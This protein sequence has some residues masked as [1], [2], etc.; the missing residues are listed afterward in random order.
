L[1]LDLLLKGFRDVILILPCAA[2]GYYLVAAVCAL[3][4]FRG[5]PKEAVGFTPAVSI[6][7]PV[8][9]VD[10]EAYENFASFCR[11]DYPDYEVL[12]GVSDPNDPAIAIIERVIQDFP[13][14]RI[15]LHTGM[16]KLGPNDKASILAHLAREASHDLLVISD[17]DTRATP[18]CLRAIA[19]P[20]RDSKVGAVTCLYR[21]VKAKSFGDVMEA[22]GISSDFFGGVFVAQQFA[23]AHFAL[24]AT[25]AITRNRLE[26]IGGFESLAEFLLDDFE[27]GRRV[28]ALGYRVELIPYAT[29]MVLPSQ[30]WR[31]FWQRQVRW[32]IGVRHANPWAH[33]G[34]LLTQ[35]LP[36]SILAAAVC[37]S[38]PDAAAYLL[39]YLGTRYLMAFSVGVWALQDPVVRRR[40]WLV[41]VR[42]ALAFAIWLTSIPNSHVTWRGRAFEVREG[43]L[44]PDEA[45]PGR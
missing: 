40:W 2:F 20:F 4:F 16:A 22:L 17:S 12:F 38:A 11:L 6:L 5:A 44:L 36:L 39:A 33:L 19:A 37:A 15:S 13:G 41:P 3:R 28:A 29:A 27:L 30:K 35:A 31:S 23:G 34:L 1:H 42:D 9:G 24:G 8:R 21:G 32:A 7:K 26:E 43:R 25:M 18:D 14:S 10:R 45:A